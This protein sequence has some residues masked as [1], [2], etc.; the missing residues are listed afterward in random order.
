MSPLGEA[1]VAGHTQNSLGT[2]VGYSWHD[3]A[4][5]LDAGGVRSPAAKA[6]TRSPTDFSTLV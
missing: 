6:L 2:S 5:I 1:S 4:I 3:V